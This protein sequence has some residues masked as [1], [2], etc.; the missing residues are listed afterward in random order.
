MKLQVYVF[1]WDET[2]FGCVWFSTFLA[3]ES[4]TS[5]KKGRSPFFEYGNF[6]FHYS[7]ISYCGKSGMNC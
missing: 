5:F 7:H 6:Y 4:L 1:L 2:M 3:C